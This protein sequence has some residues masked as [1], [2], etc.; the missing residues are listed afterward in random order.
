MNWQL[1][2]IQLPV[3]NL[4]KGKRIGIW[5]QGCTLACPGC[6]NRTLWNPTGGRS[7]PVPAL[8]NWIL[9]HADSYDGISI[10]GGEPFQQY[11]PLIA[12]LHLVKT[13]TALDVHCFSG[14]TLEE[15]LQ[16]H[17]DRLFLHYLDSLVD[18]RYLQ[19]LHDDSGV[20]GSTN[21]RLF[22]IQDGEAVPTETALTDT[23]APW[24]FFLDA[25]QDL[26]MSGIPKKGQLRH[27]EEELTCQGHPKKFK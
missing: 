13:R 22:R 5:V 4:G 7:V 17:P 23:Q 25:D 27:L 9:D 26:Y 16:H 6:L 1:N 11:A 18:G 20:R 19:N 8:F 3:Y 14:Y 15:L 12:F 24:S 10:S 21:Q 2:K